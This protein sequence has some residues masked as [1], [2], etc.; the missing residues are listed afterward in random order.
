MSSPPSCR[1]A[2]DRI[3]PSPNSPRPDD[4]N[5][6]DF[7]LRAQD[8]F[9]LAARLWATP[10]GFSVRDVALINAGAGIASR[11]YDRFAAFLA[12]SGVPTLIYDYRGIARSRPYSL[13]GFQAS[14]EEWGSKD[15]AAALL[16]LR[17]Q[18]PRARRIVVGHSI[19]GFVT[20]F[21][22]NGAL[23]DRM[24]LI[25]AHTGYWRD[26]AAHARLPM[27]LLWHVLMPTVTAVV[28]YFPG[29]RLHL[30]EDLPRSVALEWAARLRPEFW[31][32]L[33]RDD[34]SLD[35]ARIQRSASPICSN[36]RS[37]TCGSF[38]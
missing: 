1:D 19:G 11:Y 12:R 35:T 30:L 38:R 28:G 8:G 5:V 3:S 24:L 10:K 32:N 4:D 16:W 33:K 9:P 13:R 18:Y 37:H 29:K 22:T 26:Y 27:V 17:D 34:G 31:W 21:V 36:T 14:V 7:E 2:M 6:L 15:C 20:G 25:S 23:I